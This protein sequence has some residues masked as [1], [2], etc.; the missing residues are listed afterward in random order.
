MR[1]RKFIPMKDVAYERIVAQLCIGRH[2]YAHTIYIVILTKH[3]TNV[4]RCRVITDLRSYVKYTMQTGRHIGVA[5][6]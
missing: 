5:K 4:M 1:V 3:Y 6:I 2:V